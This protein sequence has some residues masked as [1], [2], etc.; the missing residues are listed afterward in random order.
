MA[1]IKCPEC[2]KNVSSEAPACPHCGYPIKKKEIATEKSESAQNNN[3]YVLV[4]RRPYSIGPSIVFIIFGFLTSIIIVGIVLIVL[5]INSIVELSQN[6]NNRRNCAYYDSSTKEVILVSYN[7]IVYKVSPY[8]IMDNYHP[9][10]DASMYV[11]IKKD[12]A[13][14]K[15]NCGVCLIQESVRFKEYY[16]QMQSG[17][18]DPSSLLISKDVV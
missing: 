6:N 10:G 18:F 4:P 8:D 2:G 13:I 16:T 3:L 7:G 12:G 11:K 15:I 1:L 14:Q 9:F 17:S 5:G